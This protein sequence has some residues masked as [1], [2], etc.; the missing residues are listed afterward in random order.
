MDTNSFQL[1][2]AQGRFRYLYHICKTGNETAHRETT[3]RTDAHHVADVLH[4]IF[5]R[6][7]LLHCIKVEVMPAVVLFTS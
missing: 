4:I 5:C 3:L 1:N 6:K 7:C 2:W